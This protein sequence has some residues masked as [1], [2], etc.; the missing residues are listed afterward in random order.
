MAN[1][2]T[3]PETTVGEATRIVEM[4]MEDIY[5]ENDVSSQTLSDSNRVFSLGT[6]DEVRISSD[7][8]GETEVDFR[9]A[10]ETTESRAISRLGVEEEQQPSP[11]NQQELSQQTNTQEIKPRRGS[12]MGQVSKPF[13]H[14]EAGYVERGDP[15][16]D[17]SHK[18]CE[19]CAHYDNE[20]NCRIVPDIEPEGYCDNYYADVAVFL[21]KDGEVE[22]NLTIWGDEYDWSSQDVDNALDKL[23]RKLMERV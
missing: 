1:K 8:R 3:V 21:D 20:G 19:T 18:R 14:E 4:V 7:P 5:G 10:Q 9:M 13:S 6:K 15:G 22:V 12:S 23:R 17:P 16:F 11:V 2:I